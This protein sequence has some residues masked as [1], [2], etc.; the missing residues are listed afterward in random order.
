MQQSGDRA[1][2]RHELAM[3]AYRARNP[4]VIIQCNGSG[5]LTNLDP[6]S[7]LAIALLIFCFVMVILFEAT[8][9]STMRPMPSPP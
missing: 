9:G 8:N 4:I 6:V 7:A 3:R 1:Q 2:G 5:M